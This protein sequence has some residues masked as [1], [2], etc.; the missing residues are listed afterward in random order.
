MPLAKHV[1][2]SAED[3][4]FLRVLYDPRRICPNIPQHDAAPDCICK[5]TLDSHMFFI[6][7]IC[8]LYICLQN[9]T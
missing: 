7:Y 5:K 9:S 4:K 8:L 2:C 3:V 6:R 1:I